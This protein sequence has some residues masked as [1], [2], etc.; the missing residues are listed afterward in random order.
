MISTTPKQSKE[1]CLSEAFVHAI[2]SYAGLTVLWREKDF[3]IDGSFKKVIH[4]GERYIES[5]VPLDF[6]LKATIN[7]QSEENDIVYDMEAKTY[8]D[9][10]YW[11]ANSSSPVRLILLCLPS[12]ELHWLNA[13]PEQLLLKHCCYYS[14]ITGDPTEN[15][16]TIRIRI[17]RKNVL[18]PS[19]LSALI[20]SIQGGVVL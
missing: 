2:A 14:S 9:F 12:D 8:N 5:G 15:A 6:Q 7:W 3:G 18:T 20:E 13:E 1:E 10:I 11:Q 19:S 17:P 4:H 16:Q